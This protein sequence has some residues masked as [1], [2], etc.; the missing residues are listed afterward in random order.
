M[1]PTLWSKFLDHAPHRLPVLDGWRGISILCV[2]AGHLLPLGFKRLQ[3]NATIAT[4]G[5]T[6]FFV[7]SGFLIVSML[8]RNDNVAS[9]LIRRVCRILPLAW[10]YLIGVLIFYCRLGGMVGKSI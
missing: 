5:M 7:L 1:Q 2:L 10:G 9:F 3:L 4:T 6:L 8:V